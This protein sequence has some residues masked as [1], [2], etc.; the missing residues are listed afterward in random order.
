MKCLLGTSIEEICRRITYPREYGGQVINDVIRILHVETVFQHDL[1]GRFLRRKEEIHQDLLQVPY[2]DLR[3]SVSR[4][5][6]RLNS[7]EDTFKGLANALGKGSVT[8]NGSPRHVIESIVRYDFVVPGEDIGNISKALDIRRR[9]SY[10][11]GVY[12][13]LDPYFALFYTNY[14]IGIVSIAAK[15]EIITHTK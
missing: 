14:N 12:P 8:F 11:I 7:R 10:G 6:I 5:I 9:A 2:R 4:D 13:S 3:K 1:V 15:L